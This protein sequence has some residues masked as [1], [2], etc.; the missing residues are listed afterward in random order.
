MVF[1]VLHTSL[2]KHQLIFNLGLTQ[3]AEA[4]NVDS[5]NMHRAASR[6]KLVF[7]CIQLIFLDNNDFRFVQ[8]PERGREGETATLF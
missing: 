8:M 2:C 7:A 5:T 6:I 1:A 3:L 4:K